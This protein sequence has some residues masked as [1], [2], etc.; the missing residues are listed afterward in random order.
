MSKHNQPIGEPQEGTSLLVATG[1]PGKKR[2]YRELLASLEAR[3]RFPDD[4][5][6]QLDVQENGTTYAENARKKAR[7]Y[8]IASGMVTIADDSGLEVDALDGAPGIHSARY[9][10]GSDA[11]RV[12][13]LLDNLE[14]VPW[15]ER[16]ARFRCVLVIA[17]RPG[18]TL[19]AEGVCEGVIAYEPRGDHGFGYD[20]IFFLPERE[21]TMAELPR[22]DKN[23]I[24]HRA[25]AVQG[26][27]P[28]LRRLVRAQ[29]ES[30]HR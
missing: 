30:G 11:D 24:S 25:Q 27:L 28:A 13:A 20:P 15:E 2:E 8:A 19:E 1:N 29:S 7:E 6:L 22:A 18:E 10:A 21:A 16:T 4:V 14:G 3:I 26:A 23:R 5:N 12:A 9:A 17:I